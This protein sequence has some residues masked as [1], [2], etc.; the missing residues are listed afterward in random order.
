MEDLQIDAMYGQAL[1][2]YWPFLF[3]TNEIKADFTG[4]DG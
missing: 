2:L 1:I 3:S 4:R